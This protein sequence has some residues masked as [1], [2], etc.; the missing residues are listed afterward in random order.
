[1]DNNFPSQPTS[2]RLE[3]WKEP[4]YCMT[5]RT[6]SNDTVLSKI[7]DQYEARVNEM[8]INRQPM[9]SWTIVQ[10]AKELIFDILD[11]K[12]IFHVILFSL[13][14]DRMELSIGHSFDAIDQTPNQVKLSLAAALA[15]DVPVYANTP[16]LEEHLTSF[17]RDLF[18]N[19]F[20]ETDASGKEVQY[21][22]KK[23]SLAK[24]FQDIKL[25][26]M[27][28]PAEYYY[29]REAVQK[30]LLERDEAGRILSKLKL[31]IEELETALAGEGRNENLLQS[32][33]TKN[34]I[35]FGVEY[36]R[37]IP[38]HLLG[39]DFEMDYALE[40]VSGI[41]DLVE[42]EASCHK[43]FTQ[44]GNPTKELVHA[45]Q[46]ILDWLAW[47]ERNS[48]YARE[49][50]PTI[51]QPLGYVVIGR[52]SSLLELSQRRLARRNIAFR[53]T[54]QILT[55]DDLLDR[56]KNMLRLLRGQQN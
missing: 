31:A 37:I 11:G 45:E 16:E 38:K 29:L 46:Q 51:Q 17:Y 52:R 10:S 23:T 15:L 19:G 9:T 43:L 39:K 3:K 49:H 22:L 14:T 48:A 32:S 13:E 50:L 4:S 40:R 2:T 6:I 27:H 5:I 26:G 41:Y 44:D 54:F 18:E 36:R 7:L 28:S 21:K 8:G 30:E 34:P 55:Y 42:I 35:L 20:S 53:G 25:T 56:A 47:V 1:M 24:N 12:P 33:L